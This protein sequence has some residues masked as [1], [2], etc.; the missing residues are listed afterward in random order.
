MSASRHFFSAALAAF[1]PALGLAQAP[2]G[3]AFTYQGELQANGRAADGV[4][5]FEACLFGDANPLNTTP[6]ACV[7]VGERPLDSAGRFTLNLDFGAQFVGTESFLDLRVR[8]DGT[9]AYVPLQPRQAIRPTPEALRAATAPWSGLAGTP[10]GF[11]DDIDNDSGGDITGVTIGTGLSGGGTSGAVSLAVDTSVVQARVTSTCGSGQAIT[12]IDAAGT[13][14]C[15]GS[16]GDI[17]GVGAGTGLSGG[18]VSGSV[19]LNI[20]NGGVGAA[21]I[22]PAQVQARVVGSCPLA[23]YL[24][25]INADGSALCSDLPGINTFTTVDDQAAI[26]VGQ[27]TSLAIGNDG[28]PVISYYDFGAGALKVAKC[29]NAACTGTA[30]ITTVDGSPNNVGRHTSLAIGSDGRP[31]ISYQDATTAALMVAKCGNAACTGPATITTVDDPPLNSVGTFSSIAIGSDSLPVISYL[32]GT[33]GALKVAKCANAA[34]TGTATITTVDDQGANNVGLYSSLAIGGDGLPVISYHDATADTLKVAKCVTVDCSGSATITTVDDTG[35][36][37][38]S[39]T[40]IA[41]GNDGLPVISYQD[42]PSAWLKVAQCANVDCTGTAT[43]TTVDIGPNDVG[44]YTSIAIGSDGLPVISYRDYQPRALKVAKCANAACSGT[45]TIT[46]VDNPANDVGEYT[47]LAIGSDGLPV[48]SYWDETAGALK[49][50]KC[51]T[52]TCQ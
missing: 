39:F 11:S 15:G 14:T 46:T 28:L 27:Y 33:A 41:I 36:S 1:M 52:R 23:T 37:V 45:A 48:I 50:A 38:G 42:A 32:D 10:P 25:G 19:I 4:F 13:V 7:A 34:C 6:L 21:Q 29:A 47:S 2:L 20:A 40:S 22:N 17:T 44:D 49:V 12:G 18:G 43:I 51:G 16:I 26:N 24:R 31:V 3:T 35:T 9:G 5:D 30:I 8:P